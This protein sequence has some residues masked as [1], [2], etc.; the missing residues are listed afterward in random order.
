MSR[1]RLFD[2][3]GLVFCAS[4]LLAQSSIVDTK[5]NLS[6]SGM[7]TLKAVSETEVCIFCHASHSGNA[8][9]PLWNRSDSPTT[10]TLYG[11]PSMSTNSQ[12]PGTASRLCLS[13]HDG[14]VALGL[15]LNRTEPIAFP[16]GMDKI[17]P[18][19]RSN[20]SEDLGDDHPLNID[21]HPTGYNCDGCHTLHPMST[22][23]L[24]C[25]SCHDPHDNTYG[26]FLIQDPVNGAICLLCH[27]QTNWNTCSH[28]TSGAT[29][30]GVPPDPWPYTE[31]N[32]VS[33]NACNNCHTSHGG[34]SQ[35][36]LLKSSAEEDNCLVCHNGNVAG[37]DVQSVLLKSSIHPVMNYNNIHSPVEDPLSMSDHVEC[38][39]CHN[40][41]QAAD[42]TANPPDIPGTLRGVTGI[43][44]DGATVSPAQYEYEVCLKCHQNN[45]AS[46]PTYVP[47]YDAQNNIRIEFAE[48]NPS[49]HP[50]FAPGRNANVPSLIAPFDVNSMIYCT[51][52]HNNDEADIVGGTAGP[53]GSNYAPLLRKQLVFT[54]YNGE[55]ESIYALCYRCHDRNV[56]V[57]GDNLV[58]RKV[59]RRHVVGVKASCTTCHDPHGSVTNTHLINFNTDYVTASTGGQLAFVDLGTNTGECYLRCH[60]RNHNPKRY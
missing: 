18:D 45:M 56:I 9:A 55:S 11:S 26:D 14:T 46:I 53:H 21:A 48:I 19:Y 5:H 41:H 6:A 7:G 49:Y 40:P 10:Y 54:D 37:K 17:P 1:R 42:I 25:S 50:V 27:N 16:V 32:S 43:D 8:Q 34:Y 2:L 58:S 57:N 38:S 44:K 52:C 60:G 22:R 12:Q 24:E 36:W 31:W 29:W 33:E 47:R 20:L 35:Y 4:L 15:V 30:N 59:H 23:N 3:A 28:N 51:D 39:D 13:C